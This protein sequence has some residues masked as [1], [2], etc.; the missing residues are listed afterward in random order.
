MIRRIRILHQNNF[1]HRDIK[2]ENFCLGTGIKSKLCY[3]IDFGLS[4][5]FISPQT[6]K[7]IVNAPSRAVV[8]TIKFL[9]HEAQSG[10]EQSRRDD[11][12]SISYCLIY[13]INGGNL[14][15]DMPAPEEE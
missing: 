15:W 14:P 13:F 12:I 6:C 5:R 7:H 3:L 9:S 11:L 4:K 2:P 8:G 1:V 10:N